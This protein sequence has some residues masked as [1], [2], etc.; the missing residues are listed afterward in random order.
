MTPDFLRKNRESG[1]LCALGDIITYLQLFLPVFPVLDGEMAATAVE[2]WEKSQIILA[3]VV[4]FLDNPKM[5]DRL[6]LALIHIQTPAHTSIWVLIA[7]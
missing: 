6:W 5:A 4:S 7:V 3:V 2:R 1:A